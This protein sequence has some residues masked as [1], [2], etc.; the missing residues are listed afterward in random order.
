MLK[1]I[2]ELCRE[3][4]ELSE[5]LRTLLGRHAPQLHAER[6]CGIV[7]AAIIRSRVSR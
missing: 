6:G 2:G 7:T 1:R 3:E 5:E 4:R